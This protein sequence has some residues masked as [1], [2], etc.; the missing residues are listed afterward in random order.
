MGSTEWYRENSPAPRWDQLCVRRQK[1][2]FLSKSTPP[3]YLLYFICV[4]T[5]GLVL[6]K[7]GWSGDGVRLQRAA[8][9]A[10]HHLSPTA[11]AAAPLPLHHVD[12]R[13]WE[14]PSSHWLY[15]LPE[16]YGELNLGC[17]LESAAWGGVEEGRW[18]R[19]CAQENYAPIWCWGWGRA[20]V[21]RLRS[22]TGRGRSTL[23]WT[24]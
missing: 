7:R 18:V 14:T 8:I 5:R 21:E 13:L 17:S 23:H 4:C 10:T 15:R 2:A 6:M 12:S 16:G 19:T 24:S 3:R 1:E 20:D 11:W 22:R 9:S